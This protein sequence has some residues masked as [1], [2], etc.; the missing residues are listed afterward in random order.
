MSKVK[1]N[2]I[3]PRSGTTITL[4][5][6][7]D[8]I[9]LGTGATQTGF[10]ATSI[11]DNGNAT[12]I[13]IDSSE[14]V[15]IGT[16]NPD[17]SSF[18]ASSSPVVDVSGTRPL[19]ILSETDSNTKKAWLGLSSDV[20]FVGGTNTTTAFYTDNAERLR[21]NSSGRVGIGTT[22]TDH[23]FQ[24]R[25]EASNGTDAFLLQNTRT[26]GTMRGLQINYSALAP[27]DSNPAIIFEDSSAVRFRVNNDGDVLNHDGSY[28]T[29]SDQRIKQNITDANSQ[30]EDIKAL[31]F[32]NFKK[33]DDVA[34]YGEANAPTELGLIAQELELISPNLVKEYPCD[35]K[36]SN[37]HPDFDDWE[38]STIKGVKY[39]I[40]Y[41][42]AVKALQEAMQKIEDLEA[43]VATLEGE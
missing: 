22:N 39:S 27:D 2:Q 16:T 24:V 25:G 34:E 3:S 36:I 1:V 6:N 11:D 33:K 38:N 28:G 41:M 40:L 29:I 26:S 13:T 4:G 30:W 10:G 8:T 43:R 32:K 23:V 42:K 20:F 21:I 18:S 7:G 37:L 31:S 19:I 14:N 12:A 17:G 9:A 5:E 15:G 35:E